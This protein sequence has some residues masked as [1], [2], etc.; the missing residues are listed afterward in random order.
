MREQDAPV[1]VKE[2]V[3]RLPLTMVKD[4]IEHL[5]SYDTNDE[6][7]SGAIAAVSP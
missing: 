3:H 2:I 1:G 7:T 6:L 4:L 5:N